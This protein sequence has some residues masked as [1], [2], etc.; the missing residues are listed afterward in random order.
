MKFKRMVSVVLVLCL[1]L[2]MFPGAALAAETDGTDTN[3][4]AQVDE[5]KLPAAFDLIDPVQGVEFTLRGVNGNA[6]TRESI[7]SAGGNVLLVFGR[8]TCPNTMALLQSLNDWH[9]VLTRH[10]V[11]VVTVMENETQVEELSKQFNFICGYNVDG[12]EAQQFN[13]R[14][15]LTGGYMYPQVVLQN[16]KGYAFYHSTGYVY[17]P[18]KLVAA[19]IQ[20]LPDSEQVP[21]SPVYFYSNQAEMKELIRNALE[22]RVDSIKICNSITPELSDEDMNAALDYINEA[23]LPYGGSCSWYNSWGSG[24]AVGFKYESPTSSNGGTKTPDGTE[25]STGGSTGNTDGKLAADRIALSDSSYVYDGNAKEPSV[26][27]F[28]NNGNII[29][30]DYYK[31]FY[32]KNTEVGKATV[33]VKLKKGYSGTLKEFFT[34]NPRGTELTSLTG[35]SKNISAKW[36]KQKIQ[37]TGYELQYSTDNNFS[38]K[39]TVTTLIKKNTTAKLTVEKLKARKT[40]YVRI[41]T[42][43]A[44]KGKKYYSAWSKVK[45]VKTKK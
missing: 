6:I 30:N 44:V 41:R 42:Y 40:Y 9:E 28:D 8:P 18:E 31:V 32:K 21:Y 11:Q 12:Y 14:I 37:T 23:G 36:A 16:S 25:T 38:G 3:T 10:N 19:A 33:K 20:K 35:K 34:I 17:E 29:S 39:T 24:L 43:K 2:A 5:S 1:M 7:E 15:N 26:T 27:V 13:Q 45:N 4:D 22:N